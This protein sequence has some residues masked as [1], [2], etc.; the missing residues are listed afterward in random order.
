MNWV[1]ALAS[2]FLFLN[3]LAEIIQA[4]RG[5]AV[6]RLEERDANRKV[7]DDINAAI[8][9]AD[10]SKLSDDDA[11]GKGDDDVPRS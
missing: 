2:L 11:F 10:G 6:G 5:R 8:D 3:R 7:D 4:E 1:K 9:R